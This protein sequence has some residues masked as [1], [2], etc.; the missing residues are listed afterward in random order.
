MLHV[1]IPTREEV[2]H[3]AELRSDICISIYLKTSPL[4]QHIEASR[5]EMGNLV[6]E[7]F[8]SLRDSGFDK[9]RLEALKEE[10]DAVIEAD[11]FWFFHANSLAVLA[12]PDSIRTYRLAN[13]LST[14]LEISDRFY[15]KPLLR[16][17]TFPHTAY[18][19]A[20]SE[21]ETR[22]VEFFA[23][24][25]PEIVH[26]ATMPKDAMEA[27]GRS[28]ATALTGSLTRESGSRG[29]KMRLAQYARKVDEALRPLLL[30]NDSPLILVTTEP[31]A[32]IY[33]SVSSLNTLVDE[34]IFTSPD[35]VTLT[36]LVKL[37]RPVLDAH[38][39]RQ[40][41]KTAELFELRAGQNRVATDLADLARAASYGMVSLLLVDFE[42]TVRGFIDEGGTLQFTE[43]AGAYGIIDEIVKRSLACGAKVL[44]VRKED[45]MGTSGA[46]AILRYSL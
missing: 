38:Y 33:R 3:L 23:D 2:L 10:L 12:T 6:K 22:L 30:L 35:K 40:L 7:A 32:S 41:T 20:L 44:A 13:N 14:Q 37:A 17:L 26:L 5:I 18:I 46:A 31:L 27:I 25:P 39:A 24:A 42:N 21:N 29:P 36:E 28:S 19:L 45:V 9:H 8:V 1:S 16:A 11:D 4:P 43:E 34:T 15:V